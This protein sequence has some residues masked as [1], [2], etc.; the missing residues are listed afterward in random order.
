MA[1]SSAA[2]VPEVFAMDATDRPV[3]GAKEEEAPEGKRVK[4]QTVEGL[5]EAMAKGMDK[6]TTLV[7]SL[8]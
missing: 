3:P 6:I 2:A 5:E 1:A 8:G 4:I 7:A